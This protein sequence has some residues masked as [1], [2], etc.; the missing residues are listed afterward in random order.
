MAEKRAS[1]AQFEAELGDL[2]RALPDKRY[3]M[4]YA[5]LPW[6]F[7]PTGKWRLEMAT[8]L[9]PAGQHSYLLS[10]YERKPNGFYARTSDVAAS[11]ALGLPRVALGRA[12]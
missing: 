3:G 6:R 2:Q 10:A 9:K 11:L 5:D 8:A 1:R 12:R 7:E 4:I